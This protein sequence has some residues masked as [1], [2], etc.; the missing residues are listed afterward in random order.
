MPKGI[1]GPIVKPNP[2][3]IRFCFAYLQYDH[4]KFPIANCTTDF[5]VELLRE[6]GRYELCTVDDFTEMP[7]EKH[8]HPIDFTKTTEKDGFPGIEPAQDDNSLWT[9]C[10]WQFALPGEKGKPSWSWRVHGFLD[11]HVFHVV[12][13]DPRHLLD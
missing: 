2:L 11:G 7:N 1:K 12:W 9:D 3:R 6:M 8:R 10:P 4:P 5:H 13:L